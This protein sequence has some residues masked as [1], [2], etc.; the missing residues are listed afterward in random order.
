VAAGLLFSIEIF[1]PDALILKLVT[2]LKLEWQQSI[3]LTTK[4]WL[5]VNI[6][7]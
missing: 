5:M 2:G 6:T 7:S 4:P 3:A 1:L